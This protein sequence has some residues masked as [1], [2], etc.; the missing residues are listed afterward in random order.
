MG[1]AKPVNLPSIS[2]STKKKATEYFQSMLSRYVDGQEIEQT[3]HVL[4]YEL[5]LKHPE[6]DGKIGNGVKRF[7]KERSPDHP[8][9]CF[10]IERQNGSPTDFSYKECITN[11]KPTLEQYFYRA[12]RQSV[13]ERLIAEKNSLFDKGNVRCCKTNEVL[14]KDNSEYRHA[15]PKFHEIVRDFKEILNRPLDES[16]FYESTDMQYTTRFSDKSIESQFIEFHQRIA[17][18]AV[19]RKYER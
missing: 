13:T 10:H 1:K 17:N 8:T 7:F 14:A 2:F 16:M 4:L 3:D 5:L 6:A 19:F 9:S 15:K 18:L 12:C 11:N